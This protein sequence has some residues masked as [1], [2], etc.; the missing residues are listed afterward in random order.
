M[1]ERVEHNTSRSETHLLQGR[2]LLFVAVLPSL[3]PLLSVSAQ[4]MQLPCTMAIYYMYA[5]VANKLGHLLWYWGAFQ[6]SFKLV[7]RIYVSCSCLFEDAR[8]P[9]SVNLVGAVRV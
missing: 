6:I 2:C 4:G 1:S 3:P 5:Y 8:D 9:A 7:M